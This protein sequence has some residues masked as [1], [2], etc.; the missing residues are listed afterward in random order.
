MIDSQALW[1]YVATGGLG[2]TK[3]TEPNGFV[4]DPPTGG[5][6]NYLLGDSALQMQVYIKPVPIPQSVWLL[7]SALGGLSLWARRR[8]VVTLRRHSAQN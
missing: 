8:R 3:Y 5:S 7:L 6:G 1:L 4:G 2:L